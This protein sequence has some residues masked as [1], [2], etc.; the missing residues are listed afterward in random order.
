MVLNKHHHGGS[1]PWPAVN[2]MRPSI[3]G[4]P[5]RV[6]IHGDREQVIR[7]FEAYLLDRVENDPAFAKRVLKL[8]GKDLCCCCAPLAC[9]GDV[10]E[11]IAKRLF[12]QQF[13]D[14]V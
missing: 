10:L 5:F 14:L 13:D 6:G 11:K 3:Y 1:V 9:H 12:E 2:I 7:K 8:Y 4:N